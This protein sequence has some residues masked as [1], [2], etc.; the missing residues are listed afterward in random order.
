VKCG[1]ATVRAAA[2]GFDHGTAGTKAV[3]RPHLE[4][5][6]RGVV[7]PLQVDLWTFGCTSCGYIEQ[8]LLD[9]EAI[10]LMQQSWMPIPAAGRAPSQ[11][12]AT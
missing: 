11:G 12:P 8:Y 3:L 5:G 6:F 2:N 7:R 10:A 4:P 1:A 9:P